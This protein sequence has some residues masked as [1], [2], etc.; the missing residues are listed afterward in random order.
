MPSLRF[1]YIDPDFS[2]QLGW[3]V[4]IVGVVGCN[5]CNLDVEQDCTALGVVHT[6]SKITISGL[7][8]LIIYIKAWERKKVEKEPLAKG[9]GNVLYMLPKWTNYLWSHTTGKLQMS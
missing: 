1:P 9:Q 2:S 4:T 3:A 6:G 5:G 7:R 8:K